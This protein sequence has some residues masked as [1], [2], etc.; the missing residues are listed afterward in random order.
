MTLTS[1]TSAAMERVNRDTF[2]AVVPVVQLFSSHRERMNVAL[3]GV[4][5][6]LAIA[7]AERARGNPDEPQ[8]MV[9]H[10]RAV[11]DEMLLDLEIGEGSATEA[12]ITLIPRDYVRVRREDAQAASAHLRRYALLRQN[13][14]QPG[15]KVAEI[16]AGV[17]AIAQRLEQAARPATGETT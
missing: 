15:E 9:Y 14:G 7:A 16:N 3:T 13:T 17:E 5:S 10:V 8:D 12:D 2:D 11:I 6:T 4:S 1:Q